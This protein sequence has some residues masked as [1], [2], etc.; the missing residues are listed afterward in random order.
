MKKYT[1]N[2]FVLFVSI[3]LLLLCHS[4]YASGFY[5]GLTGGY[6]STNFYKTLTIVQNGS[7]TY[8]KQDNLSGDGFFAGPLL[9]YQF[10]I[11]RGFLATELDGNLSSIKYDGWF[12]DNTSQPGQTSSAT[13]TIKNSYGVSIMPGYNLNPNVALYGRLGWERGDFEYSEYKADLGEPS[14]GVTEHEWLNAWKLGAG[15]DLALTPNTALRLEYDH[16]RYNT[17]VDTSF[18]LGDGQYR[19]M[20]LAPESNQIQLGLIYKFS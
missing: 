15:V 7:Q 14:Y 9:G 12:I 8:D 5:A 17:F 19:T 18:Q 10:D 6:D 1:L 20:K 16:L 3:G 4:A 11:G 2:S 13:L